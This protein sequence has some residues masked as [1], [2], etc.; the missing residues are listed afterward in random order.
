MRK[1][2]L[3][4]HSIIG[5]AGH[6]YEYAVQV[7]RAAQEMGYRPVLATNRRFKNK[8]NISWDVYPVYKYGF[9]FSLAPPVGYLFFKRL[10]DRFTRWILRHKY[11]LIFS[12][13]GLYA[14]FTIRNPRMI[15]RLFTES[16]R[17]RQLFYL[18][19]LPAFLIFSLFIFLF[20]LA[21][22]MRRLL[23]SVLP[24]R[25]YLRKWR[26]T[27]KNRLHNLN[28]LFD[29]YKYYMPRWF[30][31]I[32]RAQAFAK[33]TRR[34]FR[35]INVG[36]GEDIVCIPT[37]SEVE[38][39]GLLRYFRKDP[40]S[41]QVTWHLVFRRNIYTGRESE[42]LQ[43]EEGL[44][45]LKVSFHKFFEGLNGQKIFCYTDTKRLTAQYNRLQ[46][47]QF[48]TLPIPIDK[49]LQNA[50]HRTY[51]KA[52]LRIIY[53]GDARQEKGYHYLPHIVQDLWT[54][55]VETGRVT[56]VFQSNFNI[57][58]GEP[59]TVIARSQLES[60]PKNKVTLI[61]EPLTTQGY[62]DLILSGDISLLPYE[63][64][65]YYARSSGILVESLA[66][67]MPVIVPAGTWMAEQ[68]IE[69]TYNYHATL[70]NSMKVVK[71]L[72]GTKLEWSNMKD[73]KM[74][75]ISQE[76]LIFQ[77]E[78][79]KS[80]CWLDLSRSISFLLISF[81]VN[82]AQ[83]GTFIRICIDQQTSEGYSLLKRTFLLGKTSSQYSS[84]ILLPIDNNAKKT[85]FSFSNAFSNF[86]VAIADMQIDYLNS[87]A[88]NKCPLGSIGLAYSNPE[89]ISDLIRDMVD[90]YPHY[91]ETAHSFSTS[92]L[93]KH[94]AQ[95]L[96]KELKRTATLSH[97]IS[98]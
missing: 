25:M 17:A 38:M 90:H 11:R 57:P 97:E 81:K 19:I 22:F 15:I 62:Q 1:F 5:L 63:R 94:N 44:R 26:N 70:R 47:A 32:R 36:K 91:R 83:P 49:E 74:N 56:F 92:W 30:F 85:L 13:L 7:L 4:D 10:Y 28:V 9:W 6:H 39:R 14:H 88:L 66:V 8:K 72:K 43:Q 77:G 87:T 27:L 50:S 65:N 93:E 40:N 69:E 76:Q 42:Y 52:P 53:L 21:K 54:D 51:V 98:S 79:A 96:I 31:D 71:T 24:F 37:L 86:P 3:I 41:T 23:V 33:N 84:S 46:V 45:P 67:G 20:V 68:F 16:T 80:F 82:N 58:E 73:S 78:A 61:T 2:I 34:L 29:R 60:L 64:D 55:Y 48:Q 12:S 75:P 35:S 59:E 89:E 95:R 18:L